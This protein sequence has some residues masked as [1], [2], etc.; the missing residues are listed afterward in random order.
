MID[1]LGNMSRLS[2][3]RH[4]LRQLWWVLLSRRSQRGRVSREQYRGAASRFRLKRYARKLSIIGSVTGDAVIAAVKTRESL[5][6]LPVAVGMPV[7][8]HPPHKAVR[9][10]S[11]IR[12]PPWMGSV[13]ACHGVGMQ[14]SGRGNP[15]VQERIHALPGSRSV[16]YAVDAKRGEVR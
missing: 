16:V 8:Q 14:D 11:R 13:E 12:L 9:A 1:Y 5:N 10:R 6:C 7:A 4:R 2:I 3:F 15:S